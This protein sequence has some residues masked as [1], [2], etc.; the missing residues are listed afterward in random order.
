LNSDITL[1]VYRIAQ[2]GLRNCVKHSGAESARVVLAKTASAIR[3]LV[4]DNGCGFNTKSA[5]MEKGLGFI[6]MK[7]RL[8]VLGGEMNVYSRRL[9]GTRIEVSVPL[10]PKPDLHQESNLVTFVK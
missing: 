5:L 2:E 7:E 8:H 1:C 6:S 10:K 9:R 3:L 4:S